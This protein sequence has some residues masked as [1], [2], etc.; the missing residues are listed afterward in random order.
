MTDTPER[1]RRTFLKGALAGGLAAAGSSAAIAAPGPTTGKSN[2][3]N[4]P[5]NVADWSKILGDG[6]TDHP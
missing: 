5:P 3:E 6:V 1:S 4:L 2:P